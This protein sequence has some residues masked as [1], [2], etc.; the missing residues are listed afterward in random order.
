[1]PQ[2]V[3]LLTRIFLKNE[4]LDQAQEKRMKL[5]RI[6]IP[7]AIMASSTVHAE[8]YEFIDY[9]KG[10]SSIDKAGYSLKL[11]VQDGSFRTIEWRHFK[12]NEN[13]KFF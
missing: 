8:R 5:Q 1:M 13:P 7:I 6:L 2:P 11:P 10:G 4:L 12:D 9:L 3:G